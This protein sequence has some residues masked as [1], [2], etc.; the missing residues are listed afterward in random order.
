MCPTTTL[1][2]DAVPIGDDIEPV[3]E[4]R[5]DVETG[6]EGE[7]KSLEVGIPTFE[8][9]Q[10]NLTSREEQE[11]E[12]CG[13]AVYR[14]WCVACVKDR[15]AGK[16]LQFELLEKEGRERTKLSMVALDCVFW[17]QENA[18]T[19]L[20]YEE[21]P[22]P[23]VLQEAKNYSCVEVV[24][25]IVKRQCRTFKISAERNTSA[26]ITEDI[27]L[28]NWTP[29]RRWKNFGEEELISFGKSGTRQI[30]SDAWESTNCEDLFDNLCIR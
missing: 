21:E 20:E 15:C 11:V 2:R 1:N 19:T 29:G 22:S 16:R 9:L 6:N 8:V 18:D 23:E 12:D 10:K 26:R 3:G 7:E 5:V 4:S 17:T 14:S 30:L 27:P 25:R 24:V 28:L 13:H